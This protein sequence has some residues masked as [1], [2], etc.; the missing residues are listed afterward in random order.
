MFELSTYGI[1]REMPPWRPE[2][3]KLVLLRSSS[4]LFCCLI[5]LALLLFSE[6]PGDDL[7]EFPPDFFVFV[8]DGGPI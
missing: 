1:E 4:S 7:K 8:F 3:L 5:S 6:V 2:K